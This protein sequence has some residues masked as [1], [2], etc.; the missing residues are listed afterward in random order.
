MNEA[1]NGDKFHQ[2]L[3]SALV[4]DDEPDC[5]RKQRDDQDRTVHCQAQ[6]QNTSHGKLKDNKA[7]YNA[8]TNN[9]PCST[10]GVLT[11]VHCV[12][13]LVFVDE[14]SNDEI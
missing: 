11:V 9:R 14:G 6:S 2:W 12:K 3:V 5:E 8:I 10:G 4:E 1:A 7:E 13:E